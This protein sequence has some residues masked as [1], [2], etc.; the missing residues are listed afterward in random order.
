MDSSESHLSIPSRFTRYLEL[1]GYTEA[2][3]KCYLH[4]LSFYIRHLDKDIL[5]VTASDLEDYLL[6]LKNAHNYRNSS[7]SRRVA[8]LRSFYGFL[9]NKGIRKDNPSLAV[10]FPRV[11]EKPIPF[12]SEQDIQKILSVI[13]N[14]RDQLIIKIPFYEGLRRMELIGLQ[15][16]DIDFTKGTMLVHGKGDKQRVLPLHLELHSVL[17]EYSKSL[18]PQDKLIQLV[19]RMIND[20]VGRY[21]KQVG[22]HCYPHLLRHSFAA[23]LYKRTKNIWLVSKMLGHSKLETTVKYLRSLNVLDDFSDEYQ[24]A[25]SGILS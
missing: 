18:Q 8:F 13:H 17:R 10:K 19:P 6:H 3:V 20:I 5:A 4:D 12:L 23:N 25:F 9:F 11:R 24:K 7:L 1:Q 15:K 2:T 14:V 22:I 21:S 16:Q